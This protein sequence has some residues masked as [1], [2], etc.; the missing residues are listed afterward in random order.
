MQNTVDRPVMTTTKD[1]YQLSHGDGSSQHTSSVRRTCLSA[2]VLAAV[3]YRSMP[4]PTLYS[5]SS[6]M[7]SSVELAKANGCTKMRQN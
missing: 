7:T 5:S 2:I 1:C 3:A 4:T 6:P